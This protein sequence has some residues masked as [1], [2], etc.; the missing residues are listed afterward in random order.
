MQRRRSQQ[1]DEGSLP[2]ESRPLRRTALSSRSRPGTTAALSE[3]VGSVQVGSCLARSVAQ[4]AAALA[5]VPSERQINL[6]V[7][8]SQCVPGFEYKPSRRFLVL[9]DHCVELRVG[10]QRFHQALPA[11]HRLN[12]SIESL[13]LSGSE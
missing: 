6:A 11:S 9:I 2:G 5:P 8:Q 1:L 12:E 7:D 10:S 13:D 3:T 4:K